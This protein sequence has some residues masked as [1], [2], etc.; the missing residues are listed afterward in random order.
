M[1]QSNYCNVK[2]LRLTVVLSGPSHLAR[3]SLNPRIPHYYYLH[4]LTKNPDMPT[5]PL[6]GQQDL[7]AFVAL[8]DEYITER[9]ANLTI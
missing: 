9:Q 8:P 2:G 4:W 6:L 1:R 3:S 7:Q 5:I